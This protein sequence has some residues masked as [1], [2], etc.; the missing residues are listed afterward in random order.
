MGCVFTRPIGVASRAGGLAVQR[1]ESKRL[2]LSSR[3]LRFALRALHQLNC[4][5]YSPRLEWKI[6]T[7]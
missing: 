4:L 2:S 7:E 5:F 1:V 3:A 6:V